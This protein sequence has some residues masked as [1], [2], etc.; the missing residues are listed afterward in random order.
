MTYGN[1]W[2]EQTETES[3]MEWLSVRDMVAALRHMDSVKLAVSQSRLQAIDYW[4]NLN[5][6]APFAE[7]RQF[8]Q[9][10]TYVFLD[11]GDWPGKI[12]QMLMA[13]NFKE[14]DQTRAGKERV[15]QGT[16][17]QMKHR[18]RSTNVDSAVAAE[19]VADEP[20]SAVPNDVL[21][22]FRTSIKNMREE[23]ARQEFV[24]G[25]GSYEAS[26]GLAW[27]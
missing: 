1:S 8:P 24:Y 23:L 13:L 5:K 17:A 14:L 16:R 4:T 15:E 2:G 26:R 9:H 21:V 22:S 12:N 10:R 25:R 18:E 7:D 6:N 11:A 20:R 27:V 3:V 19:D